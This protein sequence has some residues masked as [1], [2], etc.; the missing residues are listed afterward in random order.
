MPP[1]P[2]HAPYPPR[3]AILGGLPN[4]T[5]DVPVTAVFLVLFIMGAATHM[6]IFQVNLRRGRK[7]IPSAMV[8]GFCMARVVACT[9]RLV[10]FSHPRNV[11]V[12]IASQDR[13]SVV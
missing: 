12:G 10:W 6:T 7:F 11:S 1:P 2:K 4:R 5:L 13:K 3:G 8:F 9:M